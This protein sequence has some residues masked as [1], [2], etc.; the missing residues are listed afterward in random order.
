MAKI[1]DIFKKHRYFVIISAIFLFL[2]C[3]FFIIYHVTAKPWYFYDNF[4]WT[5]NSDRIIYIR[6]SISHKKQYGVQE[7]LIRDL[8][9]GHTLASQLPFSSKEFKPLGV[10]EVNGAFYFQS[11]SGYVGQIYKLNLETGAITSSF[12]PLPRIESLF[13]SGEHAVVSYNYGG[14]LKVVDYSFTEDSYRQIASFPAQHAMQLISAAA[15][16]T[17]ILLAVWSENETNSNGFTSL[18]R[19]DRS[20]GYLQKIPRVTAYGKSMEIFYS[21]MSRDAVLKLKKTV[22]TRTIYQPLIFDPVNRQRDEFCLE[23]ELTDNFDVCIIS[24]GKLFIK[25]TK[26]LYLIKNSGDGALFSIKELMDLKN[27]T[28]YE[29]DAFYPAPSGNESIFLHH[30]SG[31]SIKSDVWIGNVDG[32]NMHHLIQP[33]GGRAFEKFYIFHYMRSYKHVL[34]DI[35]N[36]FSKK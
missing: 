22:G 36:I 30:A 3:F 28:A 20:N 21:D 24:E 1:I 31:K 12:L 19:Y 23:R 9:S 11:S 33:E 13:C 16:K 29:L 5:P 15:S 7:L 8:K 27:F 4:V 2:S 34:Q 14:A 17:N 32:T 35:S 18:W 10:D 6:S 25:T 26:K